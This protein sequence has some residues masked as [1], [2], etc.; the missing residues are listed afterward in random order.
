M[1]TNRDLTVERMQNRQGLK[2]N[3]PQPLRPGELGLCTDSKQLFIGADPLVTPI[4]GLQVYSGNYTWV[5]SAMDIQ[6]FVVETDGLQTD[7]S[8][9]TSSAL[10]PTYPSIQNNVFGLDTNEDGFV[11][12]IYIGIL[13]TE[14]T[15]GQFVIDFVALISGVADYLSYV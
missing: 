7:T 5:Q 10:M 14:L 9:I 8:I 6:I 15:S 13:T 11:N 4:A 1:A 12:R 3:L 2:I